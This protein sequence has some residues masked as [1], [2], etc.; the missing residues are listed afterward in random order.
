MYLYNKNKH[1]FLFSSQEISD[2]NI[3]LICD[4]YFGTFK[5]NIGVQTYGRQLFSFLN[6]PRMSMHKSQQR[7][8]L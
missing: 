6:M 5:E 2:M 7:S 1:E 8:G 4:G 3:L